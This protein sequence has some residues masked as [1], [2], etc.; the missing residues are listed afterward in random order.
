MIIKKHKQIA[1][2]IEIL[3][4]GNPTASVSTHNY[5]PWPKAAGLPGRT[6]AWC[7]AFYFVLA[8]G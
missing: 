3:E 1:T 7:P 4:K 8:L 6:G 5:G 2:Y